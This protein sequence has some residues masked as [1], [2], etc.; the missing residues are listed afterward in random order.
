MSNPITINTTTTK[1]S[2]IFLLTLRH[3]CLKPYYI[4]NIEYYNGLSPYFLLFYYYFCY[5]YYL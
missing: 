3:A 2:N 1:N 5:F 4:L